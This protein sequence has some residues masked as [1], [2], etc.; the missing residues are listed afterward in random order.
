MCE[1]AKLKCPGARLTTDSRA[2][3]VDAG[4]GL[5]RTT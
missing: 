1:S 5:N 3:L 2:D 4:R